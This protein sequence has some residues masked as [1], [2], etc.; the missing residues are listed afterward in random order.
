MEAKLWCGLVLSGSRWVSSRYYTVS[1]KNVWGWSCR[2][3]GARERSTGPLIRWTLFLF[4]PEFIPQVCLVVLLHFD[5]RHR[6]LDSDIL[7]CSVQKNAENLMLTGLALCLR[8]TKNLFSISLTYHQVTTTKIYKVPTYSN[9]IY[10]FHYIVFEGS[11]EF[12]FDYIC[13]ECHILPVT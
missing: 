7:L 13:S 5:Q 10:I 1:G 4:L 11:L 12:T 3:S 2:H 6:Y 8:V 9:S